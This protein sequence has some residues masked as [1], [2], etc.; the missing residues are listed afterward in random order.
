MTD[1]QM[2][3]LGFDLIVIKA[4]LFYIVFRISKL[5]TTKEKI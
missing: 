1:M 3:A 5:T 4:L 2:I